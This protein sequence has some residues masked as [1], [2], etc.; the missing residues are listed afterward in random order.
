M[1]VFADFDRTIFDHDRFVRETLLADPQ[2]GIYVNRAQAASSGSFERIRAWRELGDAYLDG[3]VTL[4]DRDLSAYV[5]DDAAQFIKRHGADFIIV[6]FGH[7]AFQRYKVEH[8]LWTL[9]WRETVYVETGDK[10]IHIAARIA[11][12]EPAVFV[13]DAPEQLAS[14]REHCPWVSLYE[15]RRDG[16]EGNGAHEAVCNFTDLETRLTTKS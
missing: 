11:E 7:A 12:G 9:S 13:D 16:R 5:F 8:A 14:V 4:P 2:I 15:M 3:S 6:T 10:G 1:T